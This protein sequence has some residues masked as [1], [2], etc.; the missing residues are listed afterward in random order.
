MIFEFTFGEFG[1]ATNATNCTNRDLEKN[2]TKNCW[3]SFFW[4]LMNTNL[5][6][7][8]ARFRKQLHDELLA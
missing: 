5:H 6:K 3:R 4:P 7:T 2:Y 1:L 8:N